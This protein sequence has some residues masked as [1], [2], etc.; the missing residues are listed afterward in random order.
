MTELNKF[1][2]HPMKISAIDVPDGLSQCDENLGLICANF[3][4]DHLDN[5]QTGFPV[6]F[7][8]NHALVRCALLGSYGVHNRNFEYNNSISLEKIIENKIN[9]NLSEKYIIAV[10]SIDKYYCFKTEN[11]RYKLL[12][13]IKNITNSID[14]ILIIPDSIGIFV[15]FEDSPACFMSF[16][17]ETEFQENFISPKEASYIFSQNMFDWQITSYDKERLWPKGSISS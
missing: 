15:F 2:S 4:L 3:A 12:D 8:P 13:D 10:N 16:S 14:F 17:K 1:T 11:F 9:R 6:D 7:F 5:A